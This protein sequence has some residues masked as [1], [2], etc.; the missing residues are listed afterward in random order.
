MTSL[1]MQTAPPIP[2]DDAPAP[3]ETS[4]AIVGAGITGLSLAVM[5]ADAGVPA[6]VLEA[7]AIGAVATGNT[8]AKLSLLQGRV[9]SELRAHAGDAALR[10][11]AD[12]NR[13]AQEWL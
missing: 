8:T 5:L 13:A 12:A 4:V 10:A 9:F 11:Y 2:R 1:W 6:T 7:R 3:A